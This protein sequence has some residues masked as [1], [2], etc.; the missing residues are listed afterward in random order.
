MPASVI[1]DA[2][3]VILDVASVIL[4]EAKEPKPS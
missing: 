3:S 1:L 4:S 2:A